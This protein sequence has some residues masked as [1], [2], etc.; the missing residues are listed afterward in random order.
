MN[1]RFGS[2]DEAAYDRAR[3][4]LL[5]RFERSGASRD[6]AMDVDLVLGWKWGYADGDLGTWTLHDVRECLLE[7]APRKVSMPAEEA[8]TLPSSL[9]AF[10]S[11]LAAEHMLG[12]RSDPLRTLQVGLAGMGNSVV[13]AMS[14]RGNFGMAKSLFMGLGG[15]QSDLALDPS[16]LDQ[17]ALDQLT[18]RFNS[19]S[20][21][22][23]GRLLG[24]VPTDP[25]DEVLEGLTYP[26]LP[27]FAPDELAAAAE[28]VPTL[29]HIETLRQHLGTGVR[30]TPTGNLKVVDAR[31]IGAGIGDP[32]LAWLDQRGDHLRSA[33][34]LGF[35]SLVFRLA[36]AAGAVR[37][38]SGRLLP[39]A[40]WGRLSALERAHKLYR[41]LLDK[42]AL[43]LRKGE[44]FD[45]L[46]EV[47]DDGAFSIAALAYA[48]FE[49]VPYD[50]I[51][52]GC[53][54]VCQS[55]L[56]FP[57]MLPEDAKR[58][59]VANELDSLLDV[60]GLAGVL[61]RQGS[62][63]G[64]I[65][66]TLLGRVLVATQLEERG[67][68]R[69][70]AAG[71]M[72]SRPL[73]EL[74]GR[75]GEWTPDQ[76]RIEFDHWVRRHSPEEAA[77]ALVRVMEDYTDFAWP[78]A[79][80]DLAGRLGERAEATIRSMLETPARG[81]ALAWLDNRGLDGPD[82]PEARLSAGLELFAHGCEGG[83]N[84]QLIYLFGQIDEPEAFLADAAA[85]ATPAARV[86][87]ERLGRILPDKHLAKA[88]RAA[89]FRSRN[90]KPKRLP[91]A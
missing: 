27:L 11:W 38:V 18:E 82:D 68:A 72:A 17:T 13:A 63:G 21:E 54:E 87:L 33:D 53:F 40:A 19:L 14:D 57:P 10:V 32:T 3:Q 5:E 73:V 90:P 9:S 46:S 1:L 83:D 49:P 47:L 23:R 22:E 44:R 4:S 25:W 81:H 58:R 24:L 84:G 8:R 55:Q 43:R 41:A 35:L 42:G 64:A 26:P 70:P 78:I 48:S 12:P 65:A 76:A 89:L 67:V 59:S 66:L 62:Q 86:V 88:A 50:L 80:I 39:T 85:L 74:F 71:D 52:E 79:A 31:A 2:D 60:L 61:V 7:W 45:A 56:R 28:E 6:A 34:Q 36:R 75:L 30:L 51:F 16:G 29:V 91:T 37:V 69:I 20:F 77:A 15:G